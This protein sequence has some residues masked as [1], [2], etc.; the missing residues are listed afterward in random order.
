DLPGRDL[1]ALSRADRAAL[2]SGAVP[3]AAPLPPQG[4]GDGP[5]A[6]HGPAGAG[7]R[8]AARRRAPGRQEDPGVAAQPST[9]HPHQAPMNSPTIVLRE[10]QPATLGRK[11]FKRLKSALG[12]AAP[13][14]AVILL[15]E[16]AVLLGLLD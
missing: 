1:P 16:A 5:R 15:W 9:H 7:G 8:A 12:F 6:P 4:P 14:F 13:V 11:A 2:R 3:P 10:A